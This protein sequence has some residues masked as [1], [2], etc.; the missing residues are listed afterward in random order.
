M[1]KRGEILARIGKSQLTR[2]EII[3]VATRMFLERGYTNTT[4]KA[5][6]DELDMSKGNLT[7]HY[8]TKEHLLA[9]LVDMLCE[10][11]WKLTE[12]EADK[13]YS[14][15]MAICLELMSMASACE[16]NEVARDFFVSAYTSPMTLEIIRN[17]DCERSKQVYADFC[18]GWSDEQFAEAEILVAGIEYATLMSSGD[19]V[20]LDVRISGALNQIMNIYGV[21][22]EMRRRKIEK[23]LAMDYRNIGKRIL[24][25]FR[26]YVEKTNEEAFEA[27]FV[28]HKKQKAET[29]DIIISPRRSTL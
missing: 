10:F 28:R 5:I 11:Q 13:G 18:K 25:E 4:T 24:K 9:E 17:N 21:P 14:S 22:E 27:L 3:Q 23:V 19:S 26:E 1:R 29:F 15:V 16:E 20:P 12:K 8:P 2:L 6:S 7:F